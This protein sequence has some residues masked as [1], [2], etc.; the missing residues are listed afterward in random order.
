[1]LTFIVVVF[2]LIF[3]YRFSSVDFRFFCV[4]KL[5]FIVLCYVCQKLLTLLHSVWFFFTM[6]KWCVRVTWAPPPPCSRPR[7]A[8]VGRLE[9][10][11]VW[12]P[13]HGP[14]RPWFMDG[15]HRNGTR[16]RHWLRRAESRYIVVLSQH[17]HLPDEWVVHVAECNMDPTWWSSSTKLVHKPL[18]AC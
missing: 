7:P 12:F 10:A 15:S 18:R 3:D 1:M 6:L 2:I 11:A 5:Y 13:R 4:Y 14:D 8:P 16:A 9:V 17:L